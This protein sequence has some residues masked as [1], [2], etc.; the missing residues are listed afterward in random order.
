MNTEC[1]KN[2][3]P[4][5]FA[6]AAIWLLIAFGIGFA[7]WTVFFTETG[8]GDNVE[9]IHA[10][11]LIAYGEVPYRD[12]FQHHNPLLWYLFAPVIRLFGGNALQILDAAH[13]MALSAGFA[14]LFVVYKICTRFFASRY[15]ALLSLLVLC[16]PY[17]YIYCFNYNFIFLPVLVLYH[18]YQCDAF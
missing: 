7:A 11:W 5:L 14:F 2:I 3:F 6:Q 10:T 15:A 1:E 9:H 13:A 4:R 16:P 12:F 18:V 17:Y 8:N